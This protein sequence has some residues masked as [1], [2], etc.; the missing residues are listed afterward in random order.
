[1]SLPLSIKRGARLKST[2]ASSNVRAKQADTKPKTK[3]ELK[4][5][6]QKKVF[7]IAVVA[8]GILMAVGM[9]LPALAPIFSHQAQE[10]AQ[11]EAQE[12]AKKKEEEKSSDESKDDT[13][14]ND[15][16]SIYSKTVASLEKRLQEDKGDLA[17]LLSLASVN[18]TWGSRLKEMSSKPEDI[19]K[20]YDI[21]KKSLD[22]YDAYLEKNDSLAVRTNRFMVM[23]AMDDKQA[24][25][26]GLEALIKEQGAYA[27][28]LLN[29]GV[30]YE[31]QD[32]LDKAKDAF[33]RS[34]AADTKNEYGA[35]TIADR[36]LITIKEKQD[37][38]ASKSTTTK[39][40]SNPLTTSNN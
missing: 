15:P 35:V 8:F 4:K 21:L 14:K 38:K 37:K 19:Q 3:E 18:Y 13:Q 32:E 28:A 1:M 29:L 24:A 23:Y 31:Q 12:A 5:E 20:A 10:N 30:L 11:K 6:K 27:P 2:K 34:K 25:I 26:D 16:E 7:E 36:H 40:I 39:D 33:E 22:A 17:A 9:M